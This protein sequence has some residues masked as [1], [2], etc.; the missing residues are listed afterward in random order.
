VDLGVLFAMHLRTDRQRV[1]QDIERAAGK[2]LQ[3]RAL[4]VADLERAPLLLQ[5]RALR[6]GVVLVDSDPGTR[7][8]FAAH[9][10]EAF[11]ATRAVR[12]SFDSATRYRLAR[13]VTSPGAG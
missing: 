4:S 9:V 10:L 2:L 3:A 8:R 12:S 7:S 1:L 6:D 11:C 5:H 13:A